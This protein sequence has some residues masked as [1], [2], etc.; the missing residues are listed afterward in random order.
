MTI[1]FICGPPAGEAFDFVLH[2]GSYTNNFMYMLCAIVVVKLRYF[3]KNWTPPFRSPIPLVVFFILCSAFMFVSVYI[4]PST[5]SGGIP[6]YLSYVVSL[7]IV[8]LGIP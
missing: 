3:D 6:Y 1:I 7:S 5:K 8:F 2:L 4:P